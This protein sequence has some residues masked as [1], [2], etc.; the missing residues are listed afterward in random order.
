MAE[1]LPSE[2]V[3]Y[4]SHH[5]AGNI[6]AAGHIA[7]ETIRE[8]ITARLVNPLA[9][10][11]KDDL[12][13]QVQRFATDKDLLDI[14]PLLQR[15]AYVAQAA[16]PLAEMEELEP[17][18]LE[19]LQR[20]TKHRWSHPFAL[21]ATVFVCSIGAAV[22]GWDQTGSNGA[23]LT[24]PVEFGI[25]SGSSRD[26]WLI[27]LVNAAPYISS[28][29]LGCWLS[30]PFNA[31]L[32]R[33]GATF[34]AAI[35]CI[36]TP[37]G[38]A[39]SQS[40]HQLLVTRLLMGFGMGLKGATIPMYT[41]ENSPAVIRGALVMGWQMWTAFGI[42]LGFAANLVVYRVGKIAW[43]L[44]IGSAFIPAVPLALFVF[45]CPE[46]PRWL[47]KKNRYRK[48]FESLCRLR[49]HRIQAARDLYYV[50][51]QLVIEHEMAAGST[52]FVRL[53]EL[54]TVPRIRRS[55]IAALVVFMGQ[56]F[57]GMNI[58]AFYSSTVF[59]QAGASEHTALLTSLG[60]G[61]INF[62][63][64][65]PAIFLIDRFGRRS[66]L[67]STFPHMAW[68]LLAAGFCF[69]IPESSKAHVGMIA[70]FVYA[71]TAL[72][73][74]GQGPVAFVY[75]AEAFPLSH[76]EIGNS[77][78]VSATFALASALSL[79]FP[80]MLSKFTNT[81]AFGFYAGMNVLVFIL[82]FLF[83]PDTSGYT[84]EELD[85]VFAVP[86]RRF[87]S[88]QIKKVLPWTLRRY[89]LFRR[90]EHLEPLYHFERSGQQVPESHVEEGK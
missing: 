58:I 86:T 29:F 72:Y 46:S 11:A 89:F 31:L 84:L 41:A 32:G 30:D 87:I 36:L 55:F 68:T 45:F 85:Y 48:A 22:Q 57:C 7:I 17:D 52:Y 13:L 39:L 82:M 23:N 35:F 53:R 10:I 76:R 79:T 50:H 20:E 42:F 77:W 81:G 67:L 28:A 70:F 59:V 6:S 3:E 62:A 51:A 1:K 27:G 80:L 33:R 43:R 34:L 40:W 16:V 21:Y 75:S 60:Y 74:I 54:V 2:K 56:Q 73:S 88:Y 9:G 38:G 24:F 37:I 65:I 61:I 12:M 90:G 15:G 66:L 4:A 49:K 71:F 64:A 8:N 47:M 78:A 25:A 19:G 5:E 83:V 14:L 63:F 44:Q 18:E 26:N 69:Y